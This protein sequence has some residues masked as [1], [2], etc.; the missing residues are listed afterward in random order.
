M[1]AKLHTLKDE[2]LVALQVIK[3]EEALEEL[4]K[5]YHGKK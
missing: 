4:L 5:N 1:L 2:F 3:S